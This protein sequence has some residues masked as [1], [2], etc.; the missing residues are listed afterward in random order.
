MLLLNQNAIAACNPKDIVKNVEHNY[1]Q[2]PVDCHIEFGKLRSVEEERKK[3]VEHLN[4]S[5]R[6]KDLAIDTANK[7][8]ELWQNTTYKVEDRLIRL[9]RNNDK[10]K[11][12]YFGLG[13][14]VMGAATYGA[15]RLK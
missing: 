11:W 7:R 6:L 14:F 9:E 10:I 4:E 3:Q 13:I 12:I 5:I 2:Y 15:S 8:I 1:Y